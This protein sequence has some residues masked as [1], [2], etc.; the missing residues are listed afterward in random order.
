MI[1]IQIL[2][3]LYTH[4]RYASLTIGKFYNF[5]S[6]FG[7]DGR[8]HRFP[9]NNF[10]SVYQIFT[11]LGYMIPLWKGKNP[12]YFW[13]IRSKVKVT[14]TINRIDDNRIVYIDGHILWC[15]HFLFIMVSWRYLLDVIWNVYIFNVIFDMVLLRV[16]ISFLI[17]NSN[18]TFI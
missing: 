15:T 6:N 9:H 10:S 4:W 17:C 18:D 14:V 1:I 5:F 11:K 8:P 3:C 2:Q 16:H 12:I 13:V 7:Y